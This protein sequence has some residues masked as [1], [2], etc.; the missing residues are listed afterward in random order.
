MERTQM[1]AHIDNHL[2]KTTEEILFELQ[3]DGYISDFS[4]D[5]RWYKSVRSEKD[6]RDRWLE[7]INE[8][9]HELVQNADE[10]W[11]KFKGIR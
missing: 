9:A 1:I 6:I 8:D 5:E 3:Y 7:I 4:I 2:N 10:N 11:N